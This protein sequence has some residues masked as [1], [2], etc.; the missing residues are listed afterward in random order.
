MD[1]AVQ[2]VEKE[3]AQDERVALER[4]VIVLE[5]A[6]GEASL[7][8]QFRCTPI[9]GAVDQIP[10]IGPFQLRLSI[11]GTVADEGVGR[12]DPVVQQS[13]WVDER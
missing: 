9:G 2:E 11:R 6:L 13:Q 4:T 1:A 8:A 7:V 5:L 12:F 10:E 3:T